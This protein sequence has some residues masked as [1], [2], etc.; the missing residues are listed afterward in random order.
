[1]K[2][3][4]D[5]LQ[6]VKDNGCLKSGRSGDTLSVFGRMLK[7]NLQEGFPLLTTKRLY[8]KGVIGELLWFLSGNTNIKW[9]NDNNINIWNLWAD[10]NGD[11]GKI[12]SYQWTKWDKYTKDENGIYQETH[13]N[14]IDDIVDQLKNNYNSR[15]M[16]VQAWN[17]AQLDDQKL[18]PCHTGFQVYSEPLTP[19]ERESQFLSWCQLNSISPVKSTEIMMEELQFPTRKLSLLFQ[20]RSVDLPIGAPFNI[21]SYAFL[22]HMLA[23]VTNHVVGELTYMLGDTHIYTNQLH[24]VSEQLSREP[25]S[26]PKL[27]FNRKVSSIYDFKF[28]DF[29]I[30]GY[31]PHPTIKIPVSA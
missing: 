25:R 10:E 15:R 30:V 9:L 3:Y 23:H 17:P 12:Y 27:K 1:M 4:L 22:T 14:Q 21:A 19:L 2:Q 26:L 5:L 31:D 20:Q 11:L 13:I 7:F 24:G 8:T 29:E 16:L 6:D 18:P 28:E